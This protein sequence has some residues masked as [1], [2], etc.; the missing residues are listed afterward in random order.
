MRTITPVI[1]SGGAG[2]RL[3]PISRRARPKQ[4]HAVGGEQ[5]LLQAALA[6]V[7]GPLFSR[8]VVV[9]NQSQL[10]LVRDQIGDSAGVVLEPVG[11]NTGPCAVVA[12]ALMAEADP[13]GLILLLP[14]DHYV[15]DVEGFRRAVEAGVEA[16]AQG[17]LVVFG[18]RPTRP[19]TGYGYIRASGAGGLLDVEAFVEKPDLARAEAYVADGRHLWNA[20]VFLFRADRLLGEMARHRLDVLAPAVAAVADAE[21]EISLIRLDAAAFESCPAVS[22]DYA[23]MEHATGVAVAPLDVG[24]SDVG[25]FQALW[26]LAPRDAAGNAVSGDALPVDSRGCY[27]DSDGPLVALSGVEDLVVVVRDGVVLVTRRDA[28]QSVKLVVDRLAESGREDLL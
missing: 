24:W 8:P 7:Q 20:G 10:Q 14:S 16:A 26:E 6:R 12:A 5:S 13:E 19:E 2:T 4:F 27:V 1:M 15:E 25:S 17:R 28:A 22:L 23:V 3:W 18:V 11:R 9:C 21:R